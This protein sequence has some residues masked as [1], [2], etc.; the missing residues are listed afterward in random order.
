M[1]L[2]KDILE[3]ILGFEE[4]RGIFT[5]GESDLVSLLFDV[6]FQA[7]FPRQRKGCHATEL[8]TR[9]KEL[10][11]DP[12]VN[13]IIHGNSETKKEV[14]IYLRTKTCSQISV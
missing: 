1:S 9:L 13:K 7:S 8:D 14:I 12:I 5:R 4:R 6:L 3:N 11:I 10:C 2:E